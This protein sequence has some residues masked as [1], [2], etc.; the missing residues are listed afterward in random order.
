M[1][2]VRFIFYL[3]GLLCFGFLIAHDIRA[4]E[5]PVLVKDINVGS[6]NSDPF[7]G[8]GIGDAVYFRADDGTNGVELWKSDGTESGTQLVKDICPGICNSVPQWLT[9]MNGILYFQAYDGVD[10]W[11]L[12]KSD[13][14]EAGTQLVEDINP[15]GDENVGF[16]T[17]VNGYLYFTATDGV[18][19]SELW[20]SDGT[21][22]GTAMV[23]DGNPGSGNTSFWM[24][25]FIGNDNY[26]FFAADI[27]GGVTS[28]ELWRSD[29]TE[30]GTVM[31]KDIYPGINGSSPDIFFVAEDG[32]LFFRANDGVHGPEL[33]KSDGTDSGTQ[34][35][36]DIRAGNFAPFGTEKFVEIGEYVYF[37]ANDGTNGAEIWRSDGTDIGTQMIRDINT[38][39]S[40][41]PE[42]LAALN[43]SLYFTA[44][45][46]SN[47]YELWK[48]DGTEDGTVMVRDIQTGSGSSWPYEKTEAGGFLYFSTNDG[49][50]GEE[51]WKTDGTE[52]GTS[53][54]YDINSG[55]G[56]S[57]P[58]II[59]DVGGVLFIEAD[60]GTL[61][62]ELWEMVFAVDPLV[63][64][65]SVSN[66]G[67]VSATGN[68]SV[69]DT[70]GENPERFIQWGA[71]SGVYTDSCSAGEGGVGSYSCGLTGLLPDTVYYVRAYATNSAGTNYG[72]EMN[73]T[74]ADGR[75]EINTDAVSDIGAFY[76]M[77]NATLTDIGSEDSDVFIQWGTSP[78]TYTDN[79]YAGNDGVGDYFCNMIGLSPEATYYVRAY[80]TNGMGTAYGSEISFTTSEQPILGGEL[81]MVKD[82]LPGE[83]GSFPDYLTDIDGE[84]FF[85]GRDGACIVYVEEIPTFPCIGGA[86]A[87]LELWKS[88][89]TAAGTQM[90]K[91]I[92]LDDDSNVEYIIELDGLAYF[93]AD[94]GI[95]GNELWKSD[96]TEG[97]TEMVKD[98][99]IGSGS[100]D[101]LSVVNVGGMLYFSANDGIHGYELWK[102]DGTNVGTQLVKDINTTDGSAPDEFVELDGA[103]Y[104]Y[105][106]D[107]IHGYELWKSDGT[108]AG[109]QLVK[110]INLTADSFPDGFVEFDG[111]LYFR[112]DDGVNGTEFWKSDGTD[113]GTQMVKDIN[114]G[115]AQGY[116]EN[117]FEFN[118]ALYFSANDGEHGYELWK[119]DGT[120]A[121]TQMMGDFN[122]SGDFYPSMFIEFDGF[123][124]FSAYDE[125]HGAE[126]WKSDGTESGTQML[127]DINPSGNANPGKFVEFN[128]L[129]YFLAYD[130]V[131]GSEL[132]KSD[133]TPGN[134]QLVYDIYPGESDGFRDDFVSSGGPMVSGSSLFFSGE[135]DVYG[136][137]LWKASGAAEINESSV[138]TQL[139]SNIGSTSATGSGQIT[140][141]GG[142]NPER[143]IQWGTQPGTY[144]QNCNAGMGGIGDYS[145]NLTNLTPNTTY[146]VMAYA[147]N[148]AGT[149]YGNEISFT[150]TN[151]GNS[152]PPAPQIKDI[153]E[154]TK[155]SIKFE[156]QVD[157]TYANQELDFE[158][159]I[160]N[161][162]DD[163]TDTDKQ[164]KKVDEEGRLTL[165][166]DD[167]DPN[168]DYS[169]SVRFSPKDQN[170]FSDY[171]DSK[172]TQTEKDIEDDEKCLIENLK[173][174]KADQDVVLT[175]DKVCKEINGILIE[176]KTGSSQFEQIASLD[177]NDTS[178]QDEETKTEGKYTYRAKG[179]AGNR[180]TGYSE[181]VSIVFELQTKQPGDTDQPQVPQQPV[182]ETDQPQEPPIV[183]KE[184]EIINPPINTSPTQPKKEST[185]S[186]ILAKTKEIA[187]EFGTEL[188]T[189]AFAGLAAGTAVAASST[190]IPL[191][192]TSPEPLS[193]R[194]FGVIGILSNRK[195]DQEGWGTVFDSQTKRPIRG[196][197]ISLINQTGHVVDTSVSDSQGRYG[198][199]PNAGTYAINVSKDN[200]KLQ[201]DQAEDSL[202]GE[203]YTGNAIT[204]QQNQIE[205]INI[206][207]RNTT[208]DWQDFAQRKISALT[209]VFSIIK[210]DFFLILFYAGALIS[211][212]IA[213]MFPSPLN[214]TIFIIYLTLLAYQLFFKKKS[215]GTISHIQTGKP[216]PFAIVALYSEYEPQQ[217][218]KFAVSDALGRYYL[219]TEN[220]SYLVKISGNLLGG[221]RFE[222]MLRTQVED[223]M[224]RLDVG[225]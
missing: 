172:S 196:V 8:V 5:D 164:T 114:P 135:D 65:A 96:G 77:G 190:G 141:T 48:S 22:A 194:L 29:G 116:P 72:S 222:K 76:A 35:V 158:I 99:N 46:G 134:T 110:D 11:G 128:N 49:I 159:K 197:I 79:C 184:T 108:D 201:T 146:Y 84:L 106:D 123:L 173:A 74:T 143:F 145:C 161:K 215:Y 34:L 112:A 121:G 187:Q 12:W 163:D 27:S 160:K 31:V 209:S 144:T 126:L 174:K 61:G 139:V 208:I 59:A 71:S 218:L 203:V 10:S 166:V 75:P 195:K 217:R 7:G 28:A 24:D 171:S 216:V 191:F 41:N 167:L 101:L 213:I 103:V 189:L 58:N 60:N 88:D 14:T 125:E 52:S 198:F 178:Y 30:G 131:H 102:S 19:G 43:G 223:G 90:V 67:P 176:R 53:L 154:T 147:T 42:Y 169:I 50:N 206:S 13:G 64:S 181:E 73:F 18:H 214:I 200:Y 62:N 157:L 47:G 66:I 129:L 193:Q 150:T 97:G 70:G 149:T 182:S 127:L 153:K 130:G 219:L 82:I 211:T 95:N 17:I 40:S 175:W 210:R 91:N 148:S 207:L 56:N 2:E 115:I 9:E 54:A 20:K 124:F 152:I 137:E 136:I 117:F 85:A 162:D 93:W 55:S 183:E 1:K 81:T 138:T 204:I 68:G 156:I 180:Y 109:T 177:D 26:L 38:G 165:T 36:N 4:A 122:S 205:N 44:D 87:G 69:T 107:G 192:P 179:Y 83:E 98:I 80:A 16:I 94:D 111:A 119:S 86:V 188:A 100:S 15:S 225:V 51:L 23:K 37:A 199:L 32:E 221:Q 185:L 151:S 118:D 21:S 63:N 224:V 89:G 104:F 142:E 212:G 92:N 105:A 202:Y 33:W 186:L 132:W 3:A 39:G 220:G 25:A 78:G 6:A 57:G 140:S 155:D 120:E 45:D 168:T 170:N 113:V 133:G